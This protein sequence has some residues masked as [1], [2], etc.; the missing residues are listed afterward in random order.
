MRCCSGSPPRSCGSGCGTSGAASS[1]ELLAPRS[2][3]GNRRAGRGSAPLIRLVEPP[4]VLAH[5][6]HGLAM[7]APE[8]LLEAIE[9]DVPA[10]GVPRR[11]LARVE[12]HGQ[13]HQARVLLLARQRLELE[14]QVILAPVKGEPSW[15]FEL[16]H[17]PGHRRRRVK[18]HVLEREGHFATRAQL[19]D[20]DLRRKP[21]LELA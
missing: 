12:Q 6:G 8:Q 5:A 4:P 14:A 20:D 15:R 2:L 16:G 17:A 11:F 7:L 13:A 10:G 3:A 21:L 18:W 19:V 1:S 9:A